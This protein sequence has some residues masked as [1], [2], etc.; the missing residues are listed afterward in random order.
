[1]V[2]D[3][4][5]VCSNHQVAFPCT[6]HT[7]SVDSNPHERWLL[8]KLLWD[9]LSWL[10]VLLINLWYIDN[11]GFAQENRETW[12]IIN[13]SS[14]ISILIAGIW[15][16]NS[17][18]FAASPPS[19]IPTTQRPEPLMAIIGIRSVSDLFSLISIWSV[20]DLVF[21]SCFVK[22]IYPICSNI[23]MVYDNIYMQ[24][25]P[26]F[27]HKMTQMQVKN[28]EQIAYGE[29]PAGLESN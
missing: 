8:P 18:S 22:Q 20:S 7:V 19:W 29:V 27:F 6:P 9:G 14:S 12:S 13:G 23:G 2:P 3:V 15:R 16:V 21:F 26:S 11:I 24:Y 4:V 10:L 28:G 17:P 5:K 1:M 25:L